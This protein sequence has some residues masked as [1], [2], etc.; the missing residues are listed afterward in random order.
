MIQFI[1]NYKI[2]KAFLLFSQD[3]KLKNRAFLYII[4]IGIVMFSLFSFLS[5]INYQ[6]K[7]KQQYYIQ[8]KEL[9]SIILAEEKR[10]VDLYYSRLHKNLKSYGVIEAIKN[11]NQKKLYS[12][13]KPRYEELLK[14]NSYFKMMHFHTKENHSFLR[15]HKPD[16]FGDDLS[17]FRHIVVDTNMQKKFF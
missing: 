15:M 4:F 7:M 2:T 5:Y 11:K 6:E 8:T 1:Q 3:K 9:Q 17:N 10:I 12:F 13:I 16:R 14:E